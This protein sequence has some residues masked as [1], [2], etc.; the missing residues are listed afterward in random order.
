MRSPDPPQTAADKLGGT[1]LCAGLLA[2]AAS[3]CPDDPPAP[4]LSGAT[5]TAPPADAPSERP[6]AAETL[7]PIAPQ[8]RVQAQAALSAVAPGLAPWAYRARI[9]E[10]LGALERGRLPEGLL[11]GLDLARVAPGHEA[12]QL[13]RSIDDIDFVLAWRRACRGGDA[14]ARRLAAVPQ[15]QHG[16][17]LW[18]S[19]ALW[20]AALITEGE[21]AEAEPWALIHAYALLGYLGDRGG[22]DPLERE[23]LRRFAL[24][25]D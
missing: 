13:E 15:E 9:G 20:E 10:A 18:Q 25:H 17:L 11:S 4:P 2:L 24:G 3:G 12:A 1:L 16:R 8:R 6:R 21:L 22:V 14:V 19:C 5:T 7:P 23:L